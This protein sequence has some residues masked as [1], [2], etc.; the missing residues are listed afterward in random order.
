ME[1]LQ[2]PCRVHSVETPPGSPKELRTTIVMELGGTSVFYEKTKK[3]RWAIHTPVSSGHN[4][5]SQVSARRTA[6]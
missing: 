3:R 4:E 5:H 2:P 6:E 1:S